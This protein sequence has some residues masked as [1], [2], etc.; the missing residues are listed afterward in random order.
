MLKIKKSLFFSPHPPPLT[1][2]F[3]IMSPQPVSFSLPPPFLY[4]NLVVT[5]LQL[6]Q[7]P[8]LNLFLYQAPYSYWTSA[9]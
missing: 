3:A 7:S 4:K 1:H 6:I 9:T 8:V 2:H 5:D